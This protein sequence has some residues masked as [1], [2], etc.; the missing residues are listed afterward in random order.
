MVVMCG[1]EWLWGGY[2]WLLVVL[3]GF[4]WLSGGCRWLGVV[5]WVILGFWVATNG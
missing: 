3:S 4:E 1:C 2:W 5:S